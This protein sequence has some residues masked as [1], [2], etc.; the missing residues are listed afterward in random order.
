[1]NDAGKKPSTGAFVLAFTAIY[2]VWG[3][4]YLGIRIT[5]E[6]MPPF[7]MAGTRFLIAGALLFGFLRWR[8]RPN[9]TLRQWRDNFVVGTALLV[10]GNGLLVW[11]EQYVTS[12][13]AALLVG[14]LPVFMVLTEWAWPGGQ[15]PNFAVFVGMALGAAGVAWLTAPWSSGLKQSIDPKVVALILVGSACWAVG[16]IYSRHARPSAPPFMGSALQMICGGSAALLT[17]VLRGE[18]RGLDVS[19]FSRQSW[20]AFVYLVLVGS[21]IG[22]ST[23]VWLMKHST[24][25]RVSTYAYV[26]PVVAVFLGWLFLGEPVTTRTV[27]GALLI[28]AAVVIVTTQKNRKSVERPKN[29]FRSV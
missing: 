6:T 1:M 15:R 27:Y 7:A 13:T 2:L 17:A 25:A 5:M 18:F 19:V 28:I 23:F 10:G 3:S 11:G 4:T 22:F 12:G 14:I 21:L 8:G 9:P 26:N 20:I 29:L 16:S 24:P